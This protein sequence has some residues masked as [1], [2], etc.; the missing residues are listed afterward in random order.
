MSDQD[1]NTKR[2]Q[3]K[4]ARFHEEEDGAVTVDWIVLTAAIVGLAATGGS[5]IKSA[6]ETLAGSISSEVGTK[7]VA[8]GD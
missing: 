1:K 2:L 6:I 8:N 4:A 5:T 7:T 3:N